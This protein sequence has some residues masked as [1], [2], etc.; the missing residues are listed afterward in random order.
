MVQS[1]VP[2]VRRLCSCEPKCTQSLPLWF[3]LK[4]LI[5][6]NVCATRPKDA[7]IPFR[8]FR[9]A[10]PCLCFSIEAF[11]VYVV[12]PADRAGFD[13]F[14]LLYLCQWH[15]VVFMLHYR[16]CSKKYSISEQSPFIHT[17][18]FAQYMH[19]R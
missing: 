8:I 10:K 5:G 13:R 1:P 4:N 17:F 14:L 3:W 15:A 11:R 7:K 12:A 2:Y 6:V 16:F 19:N 9:Q 18:R